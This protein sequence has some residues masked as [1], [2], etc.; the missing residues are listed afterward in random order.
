MDEETEVQEVRKFHSATDCS[1][2]SGSSLDPWC[3]TLVES[4]SLAVWG[5]TSSVAWQFRNRA[6]GRQGPE[7]EEC[8]EERQKFLRDPK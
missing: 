6:A 8:L 4:C 3:K 2:A 1:G 5:H 7:C